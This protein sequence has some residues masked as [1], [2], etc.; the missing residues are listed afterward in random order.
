MLLLQLPGVTLCI[1][2]FDL[3]GTDIYSN[4]PGAQLPSEGATIASEFIGLMPSVLL[5]I[6][7]YRIHKG[8]LR[9]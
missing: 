6:R 3:A 4:K 2:G 9:P 5:S 7:V 8:I 1:E